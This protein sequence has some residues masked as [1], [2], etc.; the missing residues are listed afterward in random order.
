[1][2]RLSLRVLI[3]L[4]SVFLLLVLVST[5]SAGIGIGVTFTPTCTGYEIHGGSITANRDNTG[6]GREAFVTSAR[7]GAGNIIY[8]SE[9]TYP[10]NQRVL[11]SDG[12]VVNWQHSP[13]YNPIIM[14]VDSTGGN[15]QP[16][17]LIYVV[18]GNCQTLPTYGQGIFAL[19]DNLSLLPI[20]L[21][22][23]GG[24]SQPYDPNSAPP[25]PVNPPDVVESLP[26]YAV[27]ATDNLFIRTGDGAQFAPIGVLDGGTELIVL[28]QNGKS[29]DALWWYVEV[30]G[31]TGWVKSSL[32]YLRGDLTGVPVVPSNGEIT[33][34][35]L[36][37]GADNNQIYN[38]PSAGGRWLCNIP[39]NL[40]YTVVAQDAKTAAWYRIEAT[41]DDQPALGWI[42]A[43]RG[44]L[45]NPG[46]VD[47]PVNP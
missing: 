3:L 15:S 21:P 43:D 18:T 10:I 13:Q 16:D 46:G 24:V 6:R 41:C 47:I 42:Q 9:T 39:G 33:P 37:V 12:N 32:L 23:N 30:G 14:E 27:V 11:F 29:G 26:G 35:T 4:A 25:R 44:I 28:G 20:Y 7:D 17:Q 34:P 22:A 36:Y 2:V 40:V 8:E 38:T 19:S 1:M 45:R 5:V 31:M